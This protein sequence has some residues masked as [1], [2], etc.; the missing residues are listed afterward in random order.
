M[1]IDK[2]I[3]LEQHENAPKKRVSLMDS[4]ELLSEFNAI[5]N[6]VYTYKDLSDKH[7]AEDW[8]T[9]ECPI[10]GEFRILIYI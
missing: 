7:T 10:H 3:Q 1:G 4:S 8:L 9:I 6:N 5:H 2:L